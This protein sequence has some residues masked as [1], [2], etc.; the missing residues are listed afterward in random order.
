MRQFG[1]FVAVLSLA[2]A[3]ACATAAQETSS[4]SGS[5]PKVL[6]ITREFVKPGKAGM[7]H[8]KSESAFVE[9]MARAKWPTHYIGMTSLSGKSRALYLTS[10]ESFDAWQKDTDAVTKHATL[11]V[12]LEHAAVADG[13]LLDSLDQAVF[14]FRDEMSLHPRADLSQMRYMEL[15]LFHVRPGK[16]RQWTEV[17]KMAKAGY[18]KG[19]PGAHWGMFEQ[20]FGGESGTYLLMISHKTLAEIDKG[21]ADDKQFDA[22]MGEEGLKKFGDLYA[23]CCEAS[24]HQLF[25]FNPHQSYVQEEWIKADPSF[26]KPT[27][28]ATSAKAYAQ[29]KKPNP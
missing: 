22:A 10:Y 3:Y 15:L 25:A 28:V 17:V 7:A 27:P 26:W 2:A 1:R 20:I 11:P 24:Q 14:Y 29:E 19:V 18:E 16:E 6:Q 9:A 21:F 8:D 23:E 13:E 4:G 12:A 5:I